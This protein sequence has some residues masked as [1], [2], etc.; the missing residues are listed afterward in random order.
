MTGTPDTIITVNKKMS[1]NTRSYTADVRTV[2]VVI[3]VV[4]LRPAVSADD[5]DDG[6]MVGRS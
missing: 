2:V 3:D 5:V 1:I 6:L 4:D